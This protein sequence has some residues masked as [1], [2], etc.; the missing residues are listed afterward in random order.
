M[1]YVNPKAGYK[2]KGKETTVSS[3]KPNKNSCS[4]SKEVNRYDPVKS[5][6][7]TNPKIEKV[8]REFPEFHRLIT[9]MDDL[10]LHV[11]QL[12]AHRPTIKLARGVK[13]HDKLIKEAEE[14]LDRKRKQVIEYSKTHHIDMR[15]MLIG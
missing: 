1:A 6:K 7:G 10:K 4:S 8:Y 14:K 2:R 5:Y 13:K 12:R 9:E 15:D 3:K 11:I